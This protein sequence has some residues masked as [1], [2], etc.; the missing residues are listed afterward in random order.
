MALRRAHSNLSSNSNT[1][2][3]TG[4]HSNSFHPFINNPSKQHFPPTEDMLVD[5][6]SF[7]KFP[8][9]RLIQQPGKSGI[10]NSSMP[11]E[12]TRN[13]P[14]THAAEPLVGDDEAGRG[15]GTGSK[16]HQY[17]RDPD[18]GLDIE[19][20]S[21]LRGRSFPLPSDPNDT[22]YDDRAAIA[23][24]LEESRVA[25]AEDVG[26]QRLE[27][28]QQH[29]AAERHDG[30]V[31]A[32][33]VDASHQQRANSNNSNSNSARLLQRA[34]ERVQAGLQAWWAS[35]EAA[36]VLGKGK[37]KLK[38][39]MKTEVRRGGAWEGRAAEEEEGATALNHHAHARG[40]TEVDDGG[41]CVS[42]VAA[43]APGSTGTEDEDGKDDVAHNPDVDKYDAEDDT[44]SIDIDERNAGLTLDDVHW[45]PA[46]GFDF[47]AA[48]GDGDGGN[49]EDDGGYGDDGAVLD[50]SGLSYN[51][52]DATD[53]VA[54]AGASHGA[55]DNVSRGSGGRVSRRRH[56]GTAHAHHSN[57]AASH[58]GDNHGGGKARD[59]TADDDGGATDDDVSDASQLGDLWNYNYYDG[60]G[61]DHD[62]VHDDVD[63]AGRRGGETIHDDCD[64]VPG[65]DG[66]TRHNN[67]WKHAT[68]GDLAHDEG[69]DVGGSPIKRAD[70]AALASTVNL[71]SRPRGHGQGAARSRG[72][73][74]GTAWGADAAGAEGSGSGAET[75]PPASHASPPRRHGPRFTV[76]HESPFSSLP[77]YFGSRLSSVS[78]A[79]SA[80]AS[81]PSQQAVPQSLHNRHDRVKHQLERSSQSIASDAPAAGLRHQHAAA[82]SAAV[83]STTASAADGGGIA[84]SDRDPGIDIDIDGASII[85]PA[86]SPSFN[87]HSSG[88]D[89]DDAYYSGDDGDDEEGIGGSSSIDHPPS[90]LHLPLPLHLADLEMMRS[91][92]NDSIGNN[93]SS[94]V[95]GNGSGE[96][97]VPSQQQQQRNADS[98]LHHLARRLQFDVSPTDSEDERGIAHAAVIA[99]GAAV[100]RDVRRSI[101]ETALDCSS[102]S[103]VLPATT[104]PS[105]DISFL[106]SLPPLPLLSSRSPL[107]AG[108][109]SHAAALDHH[110]LWYGADG[111]KL[112]IVGIRPSP[113]AAGIDADPLTMSALRTGIKTRPAGA[114][115]ASSYSSPA[116]ASAARVHD[117]SYSRSQS[118]VSSFS[119]IQAACEGAFAALVAAR[120]KREAADAELKALIMRQRMER[121]AEGQQ[122]MH[123]DLVNDAIGK[124]FGFGAEGG[125]ADA[126]AAAGGVSSPQLPRSLPLA[127]SSIKH[128]AYASTSAGAAANANSTPFSPTA[129]PIT[130]ASSSSPALRQL[131]HFGVSTATAVPVASPFTV[132]IGRSAS[133]YAAG[134]GADA[135]GTHSSSGADPSAFYSTPYTHHHHHRNGYN[136][137]VS[138][139]AAD[140]AQSR[141]AM[142]TTS[143]LHAAQMAR[144][145]AEL[146]SLLGTS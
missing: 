112:G 65:D 39:K 91:S 6:G 69:A 68:H 77:Q 111:G 103:G 14:R 44:S 53:G 52:A 63:D 30:T 73:T 7:R 71:R 64:C 78:A 10:G 110:C 17:D 2:Q 70:D 82:A 136:L 86:S 83:S 4:S 120:S 137:N 101:E 66:D 37:G 119:P 131:K 116:A 114:P 79:A 106:S 138:G 109:G 21:Q 88:L 107:S 96:R 81:P 118:H 142:H 135:H 67:T 84:L 50:I 9:S 145:D 59:T 25:A 32:S 58:R 29:P 31:D 130:S 36:A 42:P 105:A 146:R 48:E 11:A 61:H 16:H 5:I 117:R 80:S 140:L 33:H 134:A 141:S 51:V 3:S 93:N 124:G 97:A 123:L 122:Q 34:E 127:F 104:I 95:G 12:G 26:Q 60:D 43:A 126:D 28:Q 94:S 85:S 35:P 56:K 57:A 27:S 121:L 20:I 100:D 15:A 46:D 62:E 144:V 18:A 132:G 49:H 45:L 40:S 47:D 90:F 54:S 87:R 92:N 13:Q 76:Q 23:A 128:G 133:E 22:L 102:G 99:D 1:A 75:M 139:G 8:L 89:I 129:S 125:D 19:L 143:P 72:R 74:G 108:Q 41:V 115:T 38:L 24:A 113:D 98:Q 55:D